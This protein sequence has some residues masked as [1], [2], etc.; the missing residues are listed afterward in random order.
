MAYEPE[1]EE[2]VFCPLIHNECKKYRCAWWMQ[3][4]R[5]C[6]VQVIARIHGVLRQENEK[7]SVK[8]RLLGQ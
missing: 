5:A 1:P 6:A 3:I 7:K 8:E 2:Y 4:Q